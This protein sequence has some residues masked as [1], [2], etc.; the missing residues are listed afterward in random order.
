MANEST[1]HTVMPKKLAQALMEAGMKHFDVGGM[2]SNSVPF[3]G[4]LQN[5]TQGQAPGITTQ[6]PN[7]LSGISQGQINTQG[8]Y[9]NQSS[10]ANQLMQQ[11][12]GQGPNPALAQL[13]QTT[14]QNVQNQ[15]ALMASQR[16]ASANPA[17]IARQAAMQGANTQQQAAGQAATLNAQQQL[18]A[19]QGAAGIY[20]QQASEGLNQQSISQ[21]ALAAQNSAI[22]QGQLGAENITANANAQNTGIFGNILGGAAS[23]GAL[24]LALAATGGEIT[25]D[26]IKQPEYPRKMASGGLMGIEQYGGGGSGGVSIPPLQSPSSG[27]GG[28]ASQ[29]GGMALGKYLAGSGSGSPSLSDDQTASDTLDADATLGVESPNSGMIGPQEEGINQSQMLDATNIDGDMVAQGNDLPYAKGGSIPFSQALLKG[30]KVPG[31]AEVA[32]NSEK[33][34]KEP[35]LLSPQEIVLPRSVTLSEDAPRKAAEFV[36]ELQKRKTSK[37][38]FGEVINAKKSLHDRVSQLEAMCSGGYR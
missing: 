37:G 23:G 13:N 11:S 9:F 31:K 3:L 4:P 12:Q 20:G 1:Q 29:L 21:G 16:G 22:T 27:G 5:S 19:E 32:G 2:P 24:G 15:G 36:A 6:T 25:K 7:L 26:G 8:T 28:G 35:T 38:G 33:N 17:L 10:L 14:N 30:G 34:D 18:A